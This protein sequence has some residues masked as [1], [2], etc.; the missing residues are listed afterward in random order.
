METLATL[1]SAR[2]VNDLL[3]RVH[4]APDDD[5][6][7]L[8]V[9]DA[10]LERKD[11]RGEFIA[12]QFK[13]WRGE[14]TKEDRARVSALLSKH[15][16]SWLGPLSD[17]LDPESLVFE[18]GF[19]RQGALLE[20]ACASNVTETWVEAP[21]LREVREL[22]MPDLGAAALASLLERPQ[23]RH[24]LGPRLSSTRALQALATREWP[25][26]SFGV[27]GAVKALSAALV[28]VAT[29]KAF[30]DVKRLVLLLERFGRSS[31][32]EV[33]RAFT[34]HGLQTRFDELHLEATNNDAGAAGYAL[35]SLSRFAP[36]AVVE[37]ALPHLSARRAA[38]EVVV[39][40]GAIATHVFEF[41]HAFDL[42][43]VSLVVHQSG[44]SLPGE[45]DLDA[46]KN[47][48]RRLRPT[49]AVFPAEWGT[50]DV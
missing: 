50:V 42:Q 29:G 22:V 38:G 43:G 34:K 49:R 30:V 48:L 36:K 7:K 4:D 40:A 10:L 9:A 1:C 24:L 6:A 19:L 33:M 37:V 12:L 25:F 46:L 18:K 31:V 20:W 47:D 23:L 28:T 13:A 11:P 14:A 44:G 2:R 35:T 3:A 41:L 26:V 45:S 8:V 17:V 21:A 5:T 32:A 27:Q 16:A 39:R 15:R